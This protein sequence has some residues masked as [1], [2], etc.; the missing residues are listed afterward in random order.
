MFIECQICTEG[1]KSEAIRIANQE[2]QGNNFLRSLESRTWV[3]EWN[4][5]A[6]Y[7]YL[8]LHG[9]SV[10]LWLM[11]GGSQCLATSNFSCMVRFL[12]P[13]KLI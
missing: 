13:A 5:P 12:K 2:I 9:S 4:L 8:F 3:S 6:L 7:H 1:L 10:A 11:L